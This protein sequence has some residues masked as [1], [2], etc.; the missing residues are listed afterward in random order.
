MHGSTEPKQRR[1]GG[2]RFAVFGFELNLK[3]WV[4]TAKYFGD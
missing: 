1:V 4:N 2:D 3:R